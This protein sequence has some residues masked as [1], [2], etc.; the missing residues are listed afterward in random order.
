MCQAA[1]RT[2]GRDLALGSGG[3]CSAAGPEQDMC[4]IPNLTLVDADPGASHPFSR[5]IAQPTTYIRRSWAFS[6]C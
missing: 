4:R 3:A 6:Q 2:V 1:L 5:K